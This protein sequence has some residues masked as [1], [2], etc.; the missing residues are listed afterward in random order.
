MEPAPDWRDPITLFRRLAPHLLTCV[1]PQPPGAP[2]LDVVERMRDDG[3]RN[4]ML[5]AFLQTPG[6]ECNR[7]MSDLT[8]ALTSTG[9]VESDMPMVLFEALGA[10]EKYYVALQRSLERCMTLQ[11]S[12]TKHVLLSWSV[13]HRSRLRC[14]AT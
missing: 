8:R 4:Q 9:L 7:L 14:N 2:Y 10:P 6:L 13:I 11:D 3:I 1:E 12:I 5:E